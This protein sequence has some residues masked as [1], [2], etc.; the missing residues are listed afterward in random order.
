M[1]DALGLL[2]EEEL[3]IAGATGTHSGALTNQAGGTSNS[4]SATYRVAS[5]SNAGLMSAH[6]TTLT[7]DASGEVTNSRELSAETDL[8]IALDGDLTN[9]SG[10]RIISEG[11][12]TLRG[13]G[14]GHFGALE[15]RSD[16][17]INGGAGL[18][19][20]AASISNAD[21][22]GTASG[23]LI[24]E[25]TGNLSNSG[26]L[27]S[28]ADSQYR[29]DGTFT[30][31]EADLLAE[32]DLTIEGL[33]NERAGALTNTSARIEA[34]TGHLVV[35]AASVTNERRELVLGSTTTSEGPTTVKIV[36]SCNNTN[37]G[38]P[39][40]THCGGAHSDDVKKTTDTITTTIATTIDEI[41]TI[42]EQGELLAGG[43]MEID[44]GV[45]SNSYSHIAAN[46]NLTIRAN[47]ATNTGRDLQELVETTTVTVHDEWHCG[48]NH[49]DLNPYHVGTDDPVTETVQVVTTLEDET[50]TN[51]LFATIHA[52]GTLLIKLNGTPTDGSDIP[53]YEGEFKNEAI[54][55]NQ[56]PT[57]DS[58]EEQLDAVAVSSEKALVAGAAADTESLA[59]A[60]V[61]S[62]PPPYS[63]VSL[64]SLQMSI[65]SLLERTSLFV[66]KLAPEMPYLIETRPEFIKREN[67]LGS[68]Y[69]LERVGLLHADQIL[70]RLGDSY[71]ETRLIQ[72][73]IFDLIGLRY[74]AG[75]RDDRSLMQALYD[76]AVDVHQS[77]ALTI[78]VALSPSQIVALTNDIIWLEWQTVQGQQVLV[79]RLYLSASTLENLDLSSA[80]VAGSTTIIQAAKV[81]N[82]GTIAGTDAL[83]MQTSGDLENVGG[84]LLSDGNIGIR[85]GG[86]FSN[87]SGIVAA[88]GDVGI[89]AGAIK[90]E[91]LKSRDELSDGF[92][93]RMH[94]V[95]QI[96]AGGKLHLDA[97]S[98][99]QS[100]GG[101]FGSGE[102]MTLRA[103]GDIVIQ[104]LQLE[105][106]Q[107]KEF[108]GGFQR[109]E[110]LTNEL[111]SVA[112]GGAL[113][114]L[115]GG[116]LTVQGADIAAGE[117]ATLYAKGDTI[118]ASV[119]DY[120]HDE[121]RRDTRN[122][123]LFGFAVTGTDTHRL[124]AGVDTQRTTI[125]AGGE[126]LIGSGEGDL[127][128]DT[129]SLESG[130]DITLSAEQGTVSLLSNTDSSSERNFERNEGL[131]WY[132]EKNQG[133]D[134]E[135]IEHVEIEQ[136]GK[137]NIVAGKGVVVDYEGGGPL[138]ESLEELTR[139]PELAWMQQLRDDPELEVKWQEVEAAFEEWDFESQGLTPTGA[140]LVSLI[141]GVATGGAVSGAVEGIMGALNI[142][143]AAVQ[144]AIQ[145]GLSSLINQAAVTLVNNQGDLGATLQ[146][147]ASL[148]T[149]TSLAGTMLTAGLTT[150]LTEAAGLADELLNTAPLADRVAQDVGQGL[151]AAGVDTAV[152]TVI[153]GQDF[154]DALLGSL[155][156]EAAGILGEN[157]AQEIGAAV[158]NG[159]LDT[160]G[161]LIAHT[162]LGCA[163]GLIGSG[164]CAS[165]AGGAFMGEAAGLIYKEY[166]KDWYVDRV[167][168]IEDGTLDPQQLLRDL[169]QMKADGVDIAR[170]VSGLGAGL[171]GLDVNVASRAGGNA[172]ANNALETPWDVISLSLAADELNLAL[173]E[174]D[175]LLI[176]L[177][178]AALG[179]DALMTALPGIPGGAGMLMKLARHGG[180]DFVTKAMKSLRVGG[181]ATDAPTARLDFI[182]D[183]ALHATRN[184][185][186]G[187]VV[188]GKTLED[189]KAYTKVAA[190]YEATYFKLDDWRNLTQEL[191]RDEIW[192][193]NKAFLDLQIRQGK[194][195]VLSHSPDTA[196]GAF[197]D[198]VRYLKD[199]GYR[200]ER[201]G[202][203][204]EAVR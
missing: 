47:S 54:R 83:A 5:L 25:L 125:A 96:S 202:W 183:L 30:N 94:R 2:V 35:K 111:A 101:A 39:F 80:R 12:M 40:W 41:V 67:Y 49:C 99:I 159:D 198:E 112:A 57:Y 139:S 171:A 204:W 10:G 185:D 132:T 43:N 184:A 145:A 88:G 175:T 162:A 186:S 128:L 28:G 163:T 93:E 124:D 48:G 42:S 179:V 187:T 190:H 45:L 59:A 90:N 21:R 135:T 7:I 53:G 6:D 119:Q 203:V 89:V 72:D 86:L 95:A 120:H 170:L 130:G 27:Y 73:Q 20:R 22:I 32:G 76:N 107:G 114:V 50:R 110:A 167:G 116:N 44:T 174:R 200:F 151:T 188:L 85:A 117:D 150:H 157:V 109:S 87:Q 36:V 55:G 105:R 138:D 191:S 52:G 192:E 9:Q 103:G 60:E 19:I 79:P 66:Q 122:G 148:E 176:I 195:F 136:G 182:E 168:D 154:G 156:S 147:L 165:G 131:L 169:Q 141:V 161:Q 33:E 100:I 155:R 153:E 74:V 177:A 69:F 181:H 63:I 104:A 196:T 133:H 11:Q 127:T 143:S 81:Y 158:A 121:Y 137:L 102:G 172:A 77:L 173:A 64:S 78:G 166:L 23:A 98:F 29:V 37:Y 65:D 149:L 92:A 1:G 126:L 140:A 38:W 152:S 58:S 97:A 197:L 71:V 8:E 180:A 189:G 134:K 4:G 13:R 17:L 146:Q 84:S 16:S 178:G 144:S 113:T 142:T 118:I 62:S 14:G 34:I 193:I 199:H 115:A 201:N 15:T 129:V 194:R 26:L 164:D 91:T 106:K 108:E 3:L 24:A 82:S 123:G 46:R 18:T 31:T 61:A 75:A 160:A 51:K 56:A 68:D 70:K